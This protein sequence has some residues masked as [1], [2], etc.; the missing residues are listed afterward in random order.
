MT[1]KIIGAG[2]GRT[3]TESTKTALDLLGFNCY[4]MIEVIKRGRTSIPLWIKAADD[5]SLAEWERI[6]DGYDATVD[7]PGAYFWRTLIEYYPDAKVIL[8]A[9]DADKWTSTS[10]A[11]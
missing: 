10:A 3:G 11:G 2:F 7:W 8:N 1:L 6:F 4:H 5:P 9:R